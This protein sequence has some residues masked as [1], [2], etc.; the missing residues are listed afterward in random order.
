MF[1]YKQKIFIPL[2]VATA[3]LCVAMTWL[4]FA[5]YQM[6]D[7]AEKKDA[8]D[9]QRYDILALGKA[10]TNAESGQRGYLLTGHTLFLDTFEQ[11]RLDS[12]KVLMHFEKK[13][14]DF[15]GI[16]DELKQIRD[17]VQTK[18]QVM[19]LSIQVQ[20]NAGAY[21]SHLSLNKDTG[22]EIMK[23]I[24]DLLSQADG[25]L[26][27]LRKQFESELRQR[28]LQIM[29]GAILLGLMIIGILIFSYRSTTHLFEEVL[30][31]QAV[32]KQLSHQ[33][34]HDLLT[35]L[36]N[37]R[38]LDVQ[39]ANVHLLAR[40]ASRKF[41][42]FFMDLDGFKQVNDQYGHEIG[43]ALLVEV[44]DRFRQTLRQND[45]IARFGGD[46]FVLVVDS[47]THRM[48]LIQLAQRLL[49]QFSTQLTIKEHQLSIGVSIGIAEFPLNGKSVNQ[50]LDAADKAM[51][52]SKQNGK[53][54][55]S[56]YH[57]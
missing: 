13:S 31:N 11:G 44:A 46:E 16:Q 35:G 14:Q 20:L 19:D 38:S 9:R 32:A 22:R 48:E 57:T 41:A 28:I 40:H 42:L 5:M 54:R 15:P 7:Y 36:P 6:V 47:F 26:D 1:N 21:A 10:I 43:D 8:V 29:L 2:T 50:L 34:E 39:L 3:L 17:L 18:F 27:N 51:Y 37:R 33:A 45:F 52:I 23:Q 53:N 55:Y 25:D 24:N 30:A 49:Q 12:Q 4:F 56:F